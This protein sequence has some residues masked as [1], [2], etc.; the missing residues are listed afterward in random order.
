MMFHTQLPYSVKIFGLKLKEGNISVY[1]RIIMNRKKA[2]IALGI[3]QD[4]K[5]W[6]ETTKRFNTDLQINLHYNHLINQVDS[7]VYDSYMQ[8][9]TKGIKPTS[10]LIKKVYIGEEIEETKYILLD[11]VS[12]TISMLEKQT[13]DYSKS[14]IVHYKC[15]Q[16]T[17]TEY[18]QQI[19]QENMTINDWRRGNF[20]DYQDFLLIRH[21]IFKDKKQITKA[22]VRNHISKLKAI[23][24]RAIVAEIID[25]D[26]T[27][28]FKT[29]ST[30]TVREYLTKEELNKI[31]TSSLGG[32]QSL[33]RVRDIFLFSTYTGLRYGDAQNLKKSYI[34]INDKGDYFIQTS[35]RKTKEL[36]Y[37][38]M[39]WQA[40][41]IYKKYLE[42]GTE[43]VLPRI[44][45]QRTNSYLKVIA[46]LSN[47]NKRLT[48]HMARHTFATTIMLESGIDIKTASYF[49]GHTSIKSTEVYGK[50]SD[51]RALN[52][53]KEL[54]TRFQGV[55]VMF[56]LDK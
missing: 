4:A 13:N 12:T 51:A 30:N 21:T 8:L 7:K 36:L 52:V 3:K 16:N 53:V 49:L 31:E 56:P 23:I 11:Y 37:R 50:I 1:C 46:E 47:L 6:D 29:E 9:T 26:P 45:N 38:P 44:S 20:V 27:K 24:N 2:D 41:C 19:H 55:S 5:Y 15:M 10:A 18:L 33:D 17:L 25:H 35:Q 43:Y 39:L 22:S 32:N 42:N 40:V 48:H 14:C 34:V 28:G 54:N